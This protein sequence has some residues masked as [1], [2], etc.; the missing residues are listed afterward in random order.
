[1]TNTTNSRPTA[2]ELPERIVLSGRAVADLVDLLQAV[3]APEVRDIARFSLDLLPSVF[4]TR[5]SAGS[6]KN[7]PITA[8]ITVAARTDGIMGQ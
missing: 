7:A 2:A 8:A 3:T 5:R 4:E 1:M 6:P